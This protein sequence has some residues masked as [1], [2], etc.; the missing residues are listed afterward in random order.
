MARPGKVRRSAIAHARVTPAELADWR[1]KAKAAGVP[2]SELLRQAMDRTRTWTAQAAAIERERLRQVAR[3]GNNLNQLAR[4]ANTHKA[5][6]EAAEVIARLVAIE[7]EIGK[8]ARGA[9]S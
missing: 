5:A 2:L 6:A 3:I 8:L 9:Q 4:W 7:R 1:A